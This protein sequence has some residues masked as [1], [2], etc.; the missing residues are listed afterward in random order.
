M[1]KDN[2]KSN[3]RVTYLF[4]GREEATNS[5]QRRLIGSRVHSGSL[6]EQCNNCLPW[7]RVQTD[8]GSDGKRVEAETRGKEE[9][10]GDSALFMSKSPVGRG[11]WSLADAQAN[12]RRAIQEANKCRARGLGASA[13]ASCSHSPPPGG[14]LHARRPAIRLKRPHASRVCMTQRFRLY[15]CP[16]P[17]T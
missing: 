14:L 17:E 13:R 2:K 9:R 16:S 10:K 7:S 4:P 8:S 6:V 11:E 12:H 3:L 1:G 5:G 15:L